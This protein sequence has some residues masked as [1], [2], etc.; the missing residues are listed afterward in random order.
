MVV[1][2]SVASGMMMKVVYSVLAVATM[3]ARV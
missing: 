3:S 2:A 1:E